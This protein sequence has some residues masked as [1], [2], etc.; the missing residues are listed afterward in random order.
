[1]TQPSDQPSP[2]GGWRAVPSD[3]AVGATPAMPEWVKPALAGGIAVLLLVAGLIGAGLGT[4]SAPEPTP[5]PSASP[6]PAL[7]MEPPLIV[8]DFVRGQSN[9]NGSDT[10]GQQ[11]VQ[12]DYS[13]GEHSLVFVMTWPVTDLSSFLTDAGVTD[14]TETAPDSG[15][16]CGTFEDTG[17]AACGEMVEDVGLILVSFSDQSELL[18]S[19]TLDRFKEELGQ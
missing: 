13:D 2:A 1:M 17:Q 10:I 18:V 12:A 14:P 16:Y 9:N 8:D 3:E 15:Q 5:V 11:V 19:T 6:T 7:V 4:P